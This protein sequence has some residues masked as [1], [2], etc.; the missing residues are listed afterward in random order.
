MRITQQDIERT[1][2]VGI[3]SLIG[4]LLWAALL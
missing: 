4:L 2:V 3:I 1:I